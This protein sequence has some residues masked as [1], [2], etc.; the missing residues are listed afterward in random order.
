MKNEDLNRLKEKNSKLTEEEQKQRDLYLR[1]IASGKRQGPSVGYPSIDKNW[2]K[3]YPETA[4]TTDVKQINAYDLI[5]E[6]NKDHLDEVALEFLGRKITYRE[7]FKNV[8]AVLKA[9]R[10]KGVKKGDV[11][12]MAMA[13]TP[14]TIYVM[15]ALIRIGAVTNIIDPRLTADEFKSKIV[16]SNSKHFVGLDMC[17]DQIEKLDDI[18]L[19]SVIEVS[20]V[21]SAPLPIKI[22][23]NLKKKNKR[24]NAIDWKKFIEEGKNYQG[25]LDE[26][27]ESN[28]PAV[29]LYTG[30]T[31]GTPKGV[32]LTNE[33]LNTMATTQIISE[34]NL[35]RGD[36]FL[37]FL[38]PFSAYSIVNAIHDPLFLGFKTILVPK[39]EPRD[40]PKLMAKFKPNHVL[41]GPILWDYMMTDEKYKDTDLSDLKSPISGGD[42]MSAEFEK[43]LNE[44]LNKQG[45]KYKV[46][47]G[48]GMTEVSAAACYSTDESYEEGSVGIPY[49][50][51]TVSVFNDETNEE[52]GFNQE[53]AIRISTPT[54]MKGYNNNQKATDEIIKED[55]DGKRWITTGDI[56]KIDENG[57]VFISG[58]LKRMIVRSGNKIFPLNIEN[59]ILSIPEVDKCS[60]VGMPDKEERHVPVAYIVLN[61]EGIDKEEIIANQIEKIINE[62]MPDFC[63]PTKFI[64]R[65]ELPLTG[66]S[67][68]DFKELEQESLDYIDTD[69][70]IIKENAKAIKK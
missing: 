54:M 11:V 26:E 25:K 52:L 40:F 29:I 36:T 56:G 1:D 23:A 61:E 37:N 45:C 46:Q 32:V 5:Y 42:S 28:L 65:N 31:T 39:F 70:K 14:E 68:I 6:N 17:I 49:P 24:K 18:K 41:S 62:N 47:Q 22:L 48:Y 3:H 15:Y 38:P 7:V 67:K 20:P 16:E 12:T 34:F 55:V 69:S 2:L 27:F 66:M 63:V 60:I 51:N 8:D 10:E 13:T 44:Y 30:G 19:D 21:I 59:L 35:E 53:G 64:Y 33:N 50:K 58:R 43:R 9:F 57:N 4:V